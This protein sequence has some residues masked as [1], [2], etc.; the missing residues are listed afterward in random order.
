MLIKNNLNIYL[1]GKLC[2]LAILFEGFCLFLF[3]I[4]WK[5]A[6]CV[7]RDIDAVGE[8]NKRTFSAKK[9][10]IQLQ[11]YVTLTL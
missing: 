3:I 10:A 1:K 5:C 2:T 6:T 8:C 9:D 11:K 4:L 7:V